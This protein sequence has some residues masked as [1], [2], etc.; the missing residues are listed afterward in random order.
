MKSIKSIIWGVLFLLISAFVIVG[1][2][3]YFGDISVW[4]VIGA[5]LLAM[6]F[7]SGLVRFS[8]GNMLFPLAFAAI[9]FDERLGIEKITPWPVLAAALFAT[10]GLN[11]IFGRH[12]KIGFISTHK[13]EIDIDLPW[14]KSESTGNLAEGDTSFKSEVVFSSCVRYINCQNLQKGKVENVFGNTTIYLDN[15]NLCNGHAYIKI[16]SVFGKTTLYVPKEWKVNIGTTKVFGNI[17]EKGQ[18]TGESENLLVIEG[19]AVFGSLEII[20][21]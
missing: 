18:H 5:G 14:N 11:I 10:I 20:Y 15:A 19:E 4:K 12:K 8:F 6:W 3:G 16:E 13:K 1:S 9:L 2:M 17:N 7:A 21:I